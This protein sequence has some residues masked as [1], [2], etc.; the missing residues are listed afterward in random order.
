[1]KVTVA[2]P[3]YF[4]L[5]VDCSHSMSQRLVGTT[6]SKRQAVADTVNGLLYQL[7]RASRRKD[8]YRHFFDVSLL[9]YGLGPTGRDVE[10]L[11]WTDRIAVPDLNHAWKRVAEVRQVQDGQADVVVLRQP[12]WLEPITN[13]HGHTIMALAFRRARELVAEWIDDHASSV[14]PIVVNVSDGDWTD[15]NPMEDV[16]R[17]QEMSTQL[18]PTVV[19]NCQIAGVTE[20]IRSAPQLIFPSNLPESVSQRTREMFM[21]SSVLP[22]T[23]AQEARARRYKIDDEARGFALNIPFERLVDFLQIGTHTQQ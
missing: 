23:M 22:D 18:G 4:V 14:P 8:G 5:L 13:V 16:R 10:P 6:V 21:L 1:V 20:G 2:R 11:L 19:F 9:G 15:E 17:L 12:V 7:F 3:A